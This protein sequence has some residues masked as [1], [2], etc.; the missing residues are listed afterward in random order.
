[1]K[2]IYRRE[3]KSYF[4]SMTGYV[5]IA[6]M[7]LFAGV[8]TMIVCL[9]QGYPNFEYVLANMSFSFFIIVPV[10]TMKVVSEE[11]RQRTDQLLYSL[12][13]TT[14][15][16]IL[17]KYFALLTVLAIPLGL[18]AFYPLILDMY[19]D[20]YLPA[21][22]GAL[23]AFFFMGAS[24]LAIGLYIS[25]LTESQMIAAGL[26]FAILLTNYF[27][28]SIASL[29]SV[30]ASVSYF[31][32]LGVV[33]A[34]ALAL[35]IMTKSFFISGVIGGMF[36]VLASVF[37][38]VKPAVYEGLAGTVL[39]KLSLFDHYYTFMAGSFDLTEI[40]FFVSITVLFIFLSVQSMEKK[41]WS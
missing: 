26:C 24:F 4:T 2:A 12:P 31:I 41:R 37:Y 1:M 7:L 36:L 13:I 25:S 15:D 30:S 18:F 28:T 21:S 39:Q 11:K 9:K 27:L 5:F 33:I 34:I 22:Y 35:Y 10:I 38:F 19:G 8:Y 32:V 29:I 40:A 23:V 20:V 14:T 17:G 6:F 3:F 16:V